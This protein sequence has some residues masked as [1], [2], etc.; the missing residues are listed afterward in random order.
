VIAPWSAHNLAQFGNPF[1]SQPLERSLAGGSR[2]VEYV[3]VGDDVVKRNLPASQSRMDSLRERGVDLYGNVGFVARQLLVLAP[4]LIAFFAAGAIQGIGGLGSSLGNG[5]RSH[6]NPLRAGEGAS[7]DLR[8]FVVLA[9]VHLAL[10]VWWPTTKFRYLVPLLP[11][12]F[13]IGSRFLFELKPATHRRM[14]VGLTAGLCLFTN[15]WTFVSIPSHTYYYDGGL[16]PDNF[17][18][19]GETLFVDEARR[20]RAAADAILA[21]GP[22]PILGDHILYA[23]T[24]QPL[25][26]NS[27]AYPPEVVERLVDKY[28]LRYVVVDRAHSSAY[29]FLRPTELWADD[30]F[31]VL[32]LPTRP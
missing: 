24:H 1:W 13:A 27:T 2:D 23:F 5:S 9:L 26:I 25:V 8:P 16:V 10:I 11:L 3:L 30:R 14:L 21:R 22:G 28:R 6:S 12:L 18:G 31:V 17:G 4:V 32:E 7:P 29:G 15:V 19:Q 20:M